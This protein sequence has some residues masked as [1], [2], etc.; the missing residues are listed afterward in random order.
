MLGRR[1][2]RLAGHVSVGVHNEHVAADGGRDILQKNAAR[3]LV[4]L[5]GTCSVGA[6]CESSERPA[7]SAPQMPCRGSDG[8]RR[9]IRA[10][11]HRCAVRSCSSAHPVSKACDG[12]GR[13]AAEEID[14]LKFFCL[15]VACGHDYIVGTGIRLRSGAAILPSGGPFAMWTDSMMNCFVHQA[16]SASRARRRGEG[17][18]ALGPTGQ[19]AT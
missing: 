17:G 1:E 10:E 14:A 18:V 11:A 3:G 9:C 19:P 8:I 13:G 4:R 5:P 12:R 7:T 2:D 16:A 6:L 15:K